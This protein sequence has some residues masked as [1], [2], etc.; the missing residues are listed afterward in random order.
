VRIEVTELMFIISAYHELCITFITERINS[1]PL[2]CLP[3][4]VLE[5][6]EH[7]KRYQCL[8]AYLSVRIRLCLMFGCLKPFVPRL[9]VQ[10]EYSIARV[11]APFS[12]YPFKSPN[13]SA[14]CISALN[15]NQFPCLQH[16]VSCPHNQAHR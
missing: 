11:R 10:F 13:Q 2:R 8:D 14:D 12:F 9:S 7:R 5:K 3:I 4:A 6:Q 1:Y 16:W 15:Q